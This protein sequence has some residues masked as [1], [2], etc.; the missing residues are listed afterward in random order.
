[1]YTT[2]PFIV[3]LVAYL[4]L[5]TYSKNSF[6]VPGDSLKQKYSIDDPRNPYCPCHKHQK[7]AEKE[8]QVI[9]ERNNKTVQ[10]KTDRQLFKKKINFRFN[11]PKVFHATS[12]NRNFKIKACFKKSSIACPVF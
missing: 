12:K 10:N 3:K 4:F 2:A 1:M 9:V 6:G 7:K 8:Y 11:H 5:L